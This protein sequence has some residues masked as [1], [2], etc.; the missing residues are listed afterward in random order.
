MLA[1][2]CGK[3]LDQNAHPPLQTGCDD[4]VLRRPVEENDLLLRNYSTCVNN[5]YA[6]I[7]AWAENGAARNADGILAPLNDQIDRDCQASRCIDE[8]LVKVQPHRSRASLRV[9]ALFQVNNLRA[10]RAVSAGNSDKGSHADGKGSSIKFIN[11]RCGF[12]HRVVG[13]PVNGRIA[14]YGLSRINRTLGDDTGKGRAN[15]MPRLNFANLLN[16]GSQAQHFVL[17]LMRGNSGLLDPLT[18]YDFRQLF[19]TGQ[20]TLSLRQ[21][22]F[23]RDKL[24]LCLFYRGHLR[25]IVHASDQRSLLNSLADIKGQKYDP[26]GHREFD[27]DRKPGA[28]TAIDGQ[29]HARFTR[30][31]QKC[32]DLRWSRP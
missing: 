7:G 20:V 6:R 8:R 17:G 21:D 32:L 1:R 10:K 22:F 4:D 16:V 26:A 23:L 9:H 31:D 15:F 30:L 14:P 27:L 24:R 5:T 2:L 12:G 29:N 19:I 28:D 18:A 25:R 13:Q 3:R 11:L